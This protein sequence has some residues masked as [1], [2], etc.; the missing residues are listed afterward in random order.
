MLTDDEILDLVRECDLDWHAGWAG[1][2]E[3]N[4]Y[5]RL[6][7][8]VEAALAAAPRGTASEKLI[9]LLREAAGVIETIDADSHNPPTVSWARSVEKEIDGA[10][11][12]FYAAPPVTAPQPS[13]DPWRD[14]VEQMLATTEQVASDNPR[15]SLDRLVSWHVSVALDPLVSSDARALVQ[16]GREEVA[17]AATPQG[18]IERKYEQLRAEIDGGSESMTH[19]DAMDAVRVWKSAYS[20][21]PAPQ[22]SAEPRYTLDQIADA[23]ISAEIPDSK[24]ES[25]SIA[26]Q[27]A[28]PSAIVSTC[29]DYPECERERDRL[30]RERDAALR[31]ALTYAEANAKQAQRVMDLAARLDAAQPSADPSDELVRAARDALAAMIDGMSPVEDGRP[32]HMVMRYKQALDALRRA[33]ESVPETDEARD[34]GGWIACSDR[35]PED[36]VVVLAYVR[37]FGRETMVHCPEHGWEGADIGDAE[38]THWMPLPAAPEAQGGGRG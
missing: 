26:L 31:V 17:L 9:A 12:E 20:V 30:T 25:I 4:R 1:D 14:A 23:C 15:E 16:R 2:D 22:P 13:A 38:V 34:A 3:D 32:H 35:M 5:T 8:A 24:F 11:R 7:R 18:D 27:D 37:D 19:S 21:A 6:V 29:D 36:D 28:Q 10:V 33:L